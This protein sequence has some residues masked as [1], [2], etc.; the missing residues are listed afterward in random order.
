MYGKS[1]YIALAIE[2]GILLL[3]IG[4]LEFL[5]WWR[6]RK[7]KTEAIKIA[8]AAKA[9]AFVS[10]KSTREQLISE[11]ATDFSE[12]AKII[13][14]RVQS[15]Q[16]WAPRNGIWQKAVRGV[17][18]AEDPPED[19]EGAY[20]F[21]FGARQQVLQTHI[22]DKTDSANTA[23]WGVRLSRTPNHWVNYKAYNAQAN[24]DP[25]IVDDVVTWHDVWQ[26]TDLELI[27][28]PGSCIKTII[29][30]DNDAPFRNIFSVRLRQN[31]TLEL[32]NGGA[33]IKDPQG[34]VWLVIPVPSGVD[35]N[36]MP[37][38]CTLEKGTVTIKNKVYDTLEVVQNFADRAAATFP[39]RYDPTSTTP[40]T[41]IQDTRL[42]QGSHNNYGASTQ[43]SVVGQ[44]G[45][46]QRA[47][48]RMA[49]A[50]LPSGTINDARLYV[51]A[52][53][54]GGHDIVA[55]KVVTTKQWVVG[56]ANG[57]VQAGS[58]DW[59]DIVDNTTQWATAG[60]GSGTDYVADASP[61]TLAT[62]FTLNT[63]QHWHLPAA[64]I[65][66][67]RNTPANNQGCVLFDNTNAAGVFTCRS[68]DYVGTN[69][70]LEVDYTP[71][72]MPII[73]WRI[74]F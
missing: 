16:N 65:V 17:V 10:V 20:D 24:V 2:V 33:Q 12:D 49:S 41:S 73:Y 39:C 31:H 48:F 46:R 36:G 11:H 70:Y 32:A 63:Y 3:G 55:Y 47:L 51:Y 72:V 67:W 22:G 74:P 5:A 18:S 35:A 29:V 6:N 43:L 42:V 26:S 9:R 64:W 56:T 61:P 28:E 53:A 38:R 57:A 1:F 7:A 50:T 4:I 69:P 62:G 8:A 19:W 34:V 59:Y 52:T 45:A 14:R 37:L 68:C 21:K 40:Y 71:T 15:Y 25:S 60:M 66:D 13:T 58:C 30:K 23:M 54:D 44:S 27:A